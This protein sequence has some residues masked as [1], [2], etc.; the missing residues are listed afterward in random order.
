MARYLDSR[1]DLT[2]K[3][4]F[5]DHPRLVFNAGKAYVKQLDAGLSIEQIEE[6]IKQHN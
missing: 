6:I 3:R 5:A 4:V 1:A 2:F